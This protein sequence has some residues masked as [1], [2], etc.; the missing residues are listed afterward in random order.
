LKV[1]RPLNI[2]I[3]AFVGVV[4]WWITDAMA[5]YNFE[6][7]LLF[8]GIFILASCFIVAAA[9]L[10][11]DYY[12]KEIDAINHPEKVFPFSKNTTWIIYL[13]LNGLALTLGI[14]A[15]SLEFV[16][17]FLLLPIWGLWFYSFMLKRI[18]LIGNYTIAML[19]IW[20]PIGVVLLNVPDFHLSGQESVT[21]VGFVQ[22]EKYKNLVFLLIS[23]SFLS[24]FSR[25]IIKDIQD[26]KG[27]EMVGCKTFPILVGKEFAMV[28]ASILLVITLIIWGNFTFKNADILGVRSIPFFLTLAVLVASI[29]AMYNGNDWSKRTKWSSLFIKISMVLALI[30]GLLY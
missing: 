14:F 29:F 4:F 28:C 9:Y 12:D 6:I 5:T 10:I 8:N 22:F 25:E 26:E 18:A 21:G 2:G 19:A 30:S 20:L 23:C 3:T 27:D 11:N 7:E 17:I 15:F 1:F 24:T 16:M 13:L